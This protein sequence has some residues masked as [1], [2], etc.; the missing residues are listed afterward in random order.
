MIHHLQPER[1]TLHGHFSRDL[2]PVLTISSGDTVVCS[3]LDAGW[4]MEPFAGGA[5]TPRKEFEG[6]SAPLDDGHALIG[7]IEIREAQPGMT[8]EVYVDALEPGPWGWCLAG[9]WL[10]D[11]NERYGLL[12]QGIVHAWTLDNE[13]RVG[14]NQHGHTVALRPFMGVMGMP[15]AEHGIFP[16]APPRAT[17]GNMDCRDLVAGSR[18]YLP[19]AVPGGLFSVGDG[20]AAQGHGE[21]SGTAIECPMDRVE[22]TFRVHDD[23][24]IEA[25]VARTPDAWIAMGFDADLENATFAAID[26]MLGLMESNFGISRRDALALASVVVDLHVTQIVNGVCGVHAALPIGSIG[27]MW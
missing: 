8:L 22:L 1:R 13:R 15:P 27:G 7:P 3:T 23:F 9:G 26:S 2:A 25:P 5:Y 16:T 21:I 20:H 17:G 11:F 14:R 6:R 4:G 18:L 19:I 12:D 24:P 10:S